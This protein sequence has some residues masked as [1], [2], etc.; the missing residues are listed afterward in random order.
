MTGE[1]GVIQNYELTKSH[2]HGSD[3]GLSGI[4][5]DP[6]SQGINKLLSSRSLSDDADDKEGVVSFGRL[7]DDELMLT[8]YTLYMHVT[9]IVL[10]ANFR[11]QQSSI[12]SFVVAQNVDR[13]KL[14]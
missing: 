12:E 7:I 3:F 9:L 13:V 4:L 1:V 8:I 5:V 2:H 6:F 11:S 14:S 10:A